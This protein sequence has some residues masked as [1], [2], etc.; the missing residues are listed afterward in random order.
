MYNPPTRGQANFNDVGEFHYKF[1]LPSVS[2]ERDGATPREVPAEMLEFR[3]KFLLEE[4]LEFLDGAGYKLGVNDVGYVIAKTDGVERDHAQMFDAL[5][6]LV[7]V[8]MGT[9]HFFGY[10]WQVGWAAVQRANMNKVRAKEDA[11]DSKRGS[12]FDVVKPEGWTAPD[13]AAILKRHGWDI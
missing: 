10:P 11:S 13:I 3:L 8:A 6:D 2:H 9:A 12:S 5:L 4:L 7:Y 1:G